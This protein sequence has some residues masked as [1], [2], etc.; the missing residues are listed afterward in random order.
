MERDWT[1]IGILVIK[2][3]IED[4]W[5]SPE[6]RLELLELLSKQNKMDDMSMTDLTKY[7]AEIV[8][9]GKE[10]LGEE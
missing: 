6:E 2:D 3:K 4:S 1:S 10:A 8:K 5:T 9:I 7:I